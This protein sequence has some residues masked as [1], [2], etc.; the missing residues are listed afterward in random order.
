MTALSSNVTI[1]FMEPEA[2]RAKVA[3]LVYKSSHIYAG[4]YVGLTPNGY[5]KPF[6]AGDVFDGIAHE[7]FYNSSTTSGAAS[8][9]GDDTTRNKTACQVI[10]GP[11]TQFVATLSGVSDD[12]VGRAVY[13]SDDNTLAFTGEAYAFVGRV[14]GKYA[15]NK[16]I[17]RMK[18]P[19]ERTTDG[20][21]GSMRL[22]EKAAGGFT[23][24]GA[25]AGTGY[26]ASGFAV[27]SIL[28]LGCTYNTGA[29]PQI[30]GEFD[31][32]AEVALASIYGLSTAPVS[33]GLRLRGRFCVTDKGDNAALDI[34]FGLGTLLTAN[35]KAN[36][37]HADMVDKIAFH[38][39]GNSDNIYGWCENNNT[40]SSEVDTTIDNDSTTDTYKDF[41]VI[42]R[43]S[44]SCE[45]WIDSGSGFVRVLDGTTG[46]LTTLSVASGVSLAPFLNMEKTSDDTTA[47]WLLREMEFTGARTISIG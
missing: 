47:V 36:L 17:I 24:T 34:D 32:T 39:N 10:Q 11:S 16:A 25:T 19:G 44:G 33:G 6:E 40:E 4:G 13:A 31:A 46:T 5:A 28:G 15:A 35:S 18:A 23:A 37:S 9:L 41:L 2:H 38:M 27:E 7:E 21:R 42:V 8:A 29:S 43:S 1:Q 45:L 3:R 26:L 14:T 20:D 22:Y 12:D 30:K